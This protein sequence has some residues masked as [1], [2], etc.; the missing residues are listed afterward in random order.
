M[1][2]AA[3]AGK[4]R[5]LGEGPFNQSGVYPEVRATLTFQKK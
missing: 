2:T 3:K 4:L 1:L 5:C